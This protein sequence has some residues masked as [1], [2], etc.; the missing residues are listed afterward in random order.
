MKINESASAIIDSNNF[1]NDTGI[2]LKEECTY[3]L[4][5]DPPDQIW[6]DGAKWPQRCTAEGYNHVVLDMLSFLKRFRRAKWFCLIGAIDKDES[7]QFKIGIK[8]ENYRP[9]KSGTLCCFANDARKHYFNN[10]GSM[11]I[12]IRRTG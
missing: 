5:A 1:W 9:E 11:N 7:T 3:T 12:K 8:L 10:T 6:V 2:E 4:Y